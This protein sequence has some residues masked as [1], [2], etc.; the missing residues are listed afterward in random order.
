MV[1]REPFIHTRGMEFFATRSALQPRERVI[2]GVNDTVTDGAIFHPFEL[3]LHVLVPQVNGVIYRS[4]L[5]PQ[6]GP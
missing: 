6:E 1:G 5:V 2:R 3:L 4:I